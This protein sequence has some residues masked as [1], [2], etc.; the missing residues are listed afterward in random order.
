VDTGGYSEGAFLGRFT[1]SSISRVARLGTL[2]EDVK[3]TH[4]DY[5]PLIH[6]P[7]EQAFLFLDP[8]YL[9]ATKSRLYG[10]NGELHSNFDH[11]A[12]VGEMM[13][14]PHKWLI[15]YDDSIEIRE[16]FRFALLDSW[17][18][19]YGM[20]NFGRSYAPK[21]KE[22]FISNYPPPMRLLKQMT[23]FEKSSPILKEISNPEKDR[24]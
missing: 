13:K 18:L 3:I 9:T 17:E 10:V 1:N 5:A 16:N 22:L 24:S 8:P 12:F 21:G 6:A 11:G 2:L 15:T 4:L 19:Q 14:C 20:N 23:L 7:G